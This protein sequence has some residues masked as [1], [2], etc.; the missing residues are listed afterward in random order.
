MYPSFVRY[1]SQ[2]TA[3]HSF[4][5]RF[6]LCAKRFIALLIVKYLFGVKLISLCIADLEPTE[7]P[8]IWRSIVTTDLSC[9]PTKLR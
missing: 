6:R 4:G 3:W 2:M 9:M 8:S 1:A 5:S 7:A